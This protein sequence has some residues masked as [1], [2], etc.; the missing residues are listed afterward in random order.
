[1]SDAEALAR[2][3]RAD[4]NRALAAC[5]WVVVRAM[6][7]AEPVPSEWLAYRQALRDIPDQPAFPT[8]IVWPT[9]PT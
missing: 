6:E 4:R 8:E 3:I 9:A 5:D 1:M 2:F 7:T